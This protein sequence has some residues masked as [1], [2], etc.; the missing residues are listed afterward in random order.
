MRYVSI[1]GLLVCLAVTVGVFWPGETAH[2]G[3]LLRAIENQEKAKSYRATRQATIIKPQLREVYSDEKIYYD[4]G[5]LRLETASSYTV[6][7]TAAKRTLHVEFKP[8]TARAWGID[9]LTF[10]VF[11]AHAESSETV[12][13][14]IATKEV[15][16]LGVQVVDGRRLRAY[17]VEHPANEKTSNVATRW[18]YW[19]DAKRDLLVRTEFI[20][21]TNNSRLRDRGMVHDPAL[22]DHVRTEV[23]DYL[24][25]DEDL[26]PAL[27]NTALPEG[28]KVIEFATKGFWHKP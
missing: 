23:T 26:D 16:D 13:K 17:R 19:I 25:F 5:K 14:A 27:F 12:K 24:G 7:N 4:D 20:W 21:P 9:S 15:Q 8:K 2:A 11:D 1:S 28:Y 10:S 22:N 3:P 6:V 18:T